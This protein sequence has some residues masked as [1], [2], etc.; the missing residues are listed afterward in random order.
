MSSFK[1][2][3]RYVDEDGASPG[4]VE[5]AEHR[6]WRKLKALELAARHLGMRGFRPPDETPE[7]AGAKVYLLSVVA[8]SARDWERQVAERRGRPAGPG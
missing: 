3:A 4:V 2:R 1:R 8:L 6:L 7:G 5:D